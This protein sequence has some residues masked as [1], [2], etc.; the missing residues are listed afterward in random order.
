MRASR[1]SPLANT[2]SI[3]AVVVVVTACRQQKD[4]ADEKM[5]KAL[6]GTWTWEAKYASGDHTEF[7]TTVAP[8][9]SYVGTV[10]TPNRTNGPRIVTNEGTFRIENGYLVDTVT[11]SSQTN[12]PVPRTDRYRIVR[13][14][15]REL[16]L[17][18]ERPPGGVYPTNE[19]VYRR[20]TK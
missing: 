1:Q 7:T 12:T 16:A 11:N 20:R 19:V 6:P 2:L 14:D 13:I 3:F 4:S 5:Q 9:G 17:D 8:D 15:D 18:Y 10:D